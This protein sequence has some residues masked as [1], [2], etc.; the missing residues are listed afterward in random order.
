MGKMIT[1]MFEKQ[2]PPLYM[3]VYGKI[4]EQIR[5]GEIRPQE[6]LPSRRKLA[7]HLG[8]SVNTVDAAYAQ[9]LSEGFI[10]S[11]PKRGYF[12][13]QVE[14]LA[15]RVSDRT[16]R[17]PRAEQPPQV[18]FSAAKVDTGHFPTSVWRR[19]VKSALEEERAFRQSPPK[20]DQ[21]LRESVAQYLYEARGIQAEPERIVIGA[22]TDNLLHIL[23]YIFDS[24]YTF[25]LE[26]PVYNK[27]YHI[28]VRMGH[29]VLPVDVDKEGVQ[30]GL[31]P[32][33]GKAVVYATLSHQFPLGMTVPINRRIQLINWAKRGAGRY[34]VEDDYDS[35]FRYNARPIPP[36][37]TLDGGDRVVY[38]GTFS[39][40]MAP[41]L[42][43]S[44][45]VLPR[46]LMERFEGVYGFFGSTVS[47]LEQIALDR[48]IR[49]GHYER[50][51]NRMRKLY[52]KKRE[53][54]A[55]RAKAY[56]LR[57]QGDPAG[58]HILLDTGQDSQAFLEKL[59]EKNVG[60]YSIGPYFIG[61]VPE[62]YCRMILLGF[63]ALDEEEIAMGLEAIYQ[64]MEEK[65]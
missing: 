45:M 21:A 19:I 6:R 49:E 60:A 32:E 61:P 43:I 34:I 10:E 53:A 4:K 65:N 36:L 22:G 20:G 27:A 1:L 63:G 15:E 25:A 39:K 7:E 59:L 9:L 35:E 2:G 62:A 48:F 57:L 29:K 13:C 46:E 44:Y 14:K 26:N 54:L 24:A 56:G 18:D 37:Y 8:I 17:K 64:V 16:E 11:K 23:S 28:F 55:A 12:A 5:K 3:Q 42:R 38:M 33:E 51:I 40:T 31:L 50:H 58:H 30:P 41:S 52:G 47:T